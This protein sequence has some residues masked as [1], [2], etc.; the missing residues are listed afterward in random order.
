MASQTLTIPI[1]LW[2][3]LLRELRR[4]GRGNRESGAFLLGLASETKVLRIVFYDDLDPHALDTGIIEFDGSGYVPLWKL[5]REKKLRVLADV[6][7][8]PTDWTEQSGSDRTHPMISQRGHV[9]LIVPNFA[10][11]TLQKLRGVG[12]HEY[13]G[14]HQWKS[15]EPKSGR[16]RIT[17]L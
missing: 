4:R 10:R 11:R 15:W 7:T 14:N 3:H 1:L 12:I 6:H 17:I 13:L 9:A 2:W 16:I 8:H 5:C